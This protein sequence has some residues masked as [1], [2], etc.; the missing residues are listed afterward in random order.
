MTG[1]R[2]PAAREARR[3]RARSP[4]ARHIARYALASPR[5][6]SRW[7]QPPLPCPPRRDR[8]LRESSLRSSISRRCRCPRR[9]AAR[10]LPSPP[11]SWTRPPAKL[12]TRSPIYP[13][14]SA[15]DLALA[16]QFEDRHHAT[17]PGSGRARHVREHAGFR[18]RSSDRLDAC[19]RNKTGRDAS[20]SGARLL[21]SA[22]AEIQ[23][24][25][26]RRR[27]SRASTRAICTLLPTMP[28][29]SQSRSVRSR[30]DSIKWS[31]TLPRP[32]PTRPREASASPSA[33]D[34]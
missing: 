27:Q 34:L 24:H 20:R 21:R 15:R 28:S 14:N 4:R 5:F 16:L 3:R 19:R 7:P 9:R 17:F 1:L 29:A 30:R 32:T 10:H 18:P 23:R 12:R 25:R 2:R 22:R 26:S 6:T 13:A 11:D 8:A 31:G 33:S